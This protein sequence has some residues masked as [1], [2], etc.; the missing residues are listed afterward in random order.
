MYKQLDEFLVANMPRLWRSRMLLLLAIALVTSLIFSQINGASFLSNMGEEIF[1]VFPIILGIY[2]NYLQFKHHPFLRR[3]SLPEVFLGSL[4]NLIV[5]FLMFLPLYFLVDYGPSG[6][7]SFFSVAAIFWYL[8]GLPMIFTPFVIRNYSFSE[9]LLIIVSGLLLGTLVIMLVNGLV[10]YRDAEPMTIIIY[11]LIY[12]GLVLKV[13]LALVQRR[14]NKWDKWF[15]FF[16][17]A[18]G[19]F[20]LSF[21]YSYFTS[22]D[23]SNSIFNL[24]ITSYNQITNFFYSAILSYLFLLVFSWYVTRSFEKPIK[25]R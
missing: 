22:G 5:V 6:G 3:F 15:I 14:Y 13:V 10:G 19:P 2:W 9:V 23:L 11:S 17:I 20:V 21:V 16:L 25:V 1:I 7:I 18:A 12:F 8:L 4:L 24:D